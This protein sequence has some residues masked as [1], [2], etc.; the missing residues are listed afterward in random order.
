MLGVFEERSKSL[1]GDC[2]GVD[3]ICDPGNYMGVVFV[4]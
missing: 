1:E 3:M 4:I 2:V